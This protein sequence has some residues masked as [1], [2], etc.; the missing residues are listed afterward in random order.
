[1]RTTVCLC[2]NALRFPRAGGHLWVYLNWA[3]GLRA[4]GCKVIWLEGIDPHSSIETTRTHVAALRE[5]LTRF[6]LGDDLALYSRADDSTP[7]FL[8]HH[9][10]DL[11]AVRQAD[12]LLNMAYHF[13]PPDIVGCVRRTALLDI[14][15]GLTQVWLSEGQLPIAP[16][17]TYFT[18]GETVGQPG[19][20]FPDCGLP[21]NH[22]PPPVYLG[23]WPTVASP[24]EAPFTTLT[25]WS[26]EMVLFRG[27]CFYNGKREGFWPFLDLPRRTPQ[28]LE[29]A[30]NLD[31]HYAEQIDTDCA[32]LLQHG[33]GIRQAQEVAATPW[34]YQGYIHASRGEF[35]CAK[36]SYIRLQ[37]A[38]ISDRTICYLASGKPAVVQHTGPSR[39]LP[40][41]DGLLRF[42]TM[43]EAVACLDG[44]TADY[45]HHSRRARALAE[46]YFDAEKVVRRVLERAL[47]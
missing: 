33:W 16:H 38:W 24:P 44:A 27:E 14:D 43:D 35:S 9:A 30:I 46:E 41:R 2:A 37:T 39:F 15:P 45:E 32:A 19:A 29:L 31:G 36:P 28:R 6:G 12:L 34:D 8:T 22:T 10:V 7:R 18:I 5:R 11:D 42:R 21:W 23:E 20:P 17:D 25:H 3:L 40:D 4:L 13:V 26:A 47:N 1:V